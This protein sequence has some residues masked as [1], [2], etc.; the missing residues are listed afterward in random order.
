MTRRPFQK[1]QRGAGGG[2][3][4]T[5]F[6]KPSFQSGVFPRSK[7]RNIPDISMAASVVA[8]GFFFAEGG[9]I[10]CCIGGT[11]IGAPIWAGISALGAQGAGLTRIGDIN[12]KLYS[13]GPSG[14]TSSSGLHDVTAGVNGFRGVQGFK[15]KPGY[16][17]ATGWG[18]PD[19]GILAPLLGR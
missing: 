8:P 11:S 5:I 2:G 4:S 17:R 7:K 14:N 12:P 15:A 9:A 6:A 3:H 18:T 19:I 16:D 10:T 1:C 13:L